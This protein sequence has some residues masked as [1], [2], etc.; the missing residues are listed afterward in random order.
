MLGAFASGWNI[1][2]RKK[3]L[4]DNQGNLRQVM[5]YRAPDPS[6]HVSRKDKEVWIQERFPDYWNKGLP[7][8]RQARDLP[9]DAVLARSSARRSCPARSTTRAPRSGLLAQGQ[10]DAGVTASAFN[11]SV[12]QAFWTNIQ[13]NKALADPKVAPADPPRDG[14]PHPW[15]KW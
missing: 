2:V 15:S 13:K 5:N 3:T 10:G 1:I 9:H 7:L 14:P 6:G 12:I 8:G 11:Q 4:E